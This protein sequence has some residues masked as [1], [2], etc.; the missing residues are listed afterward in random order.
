MPV[1]GGGESLQVDPFPPRGILKGFGYPNDHAGEPLTLG[2]GEKGNGT[3]FGQAL[4]L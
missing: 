1:S 2:V 4:T 3:A